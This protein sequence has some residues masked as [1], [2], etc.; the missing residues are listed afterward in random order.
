MYATH[1]NTYL[2]ASRELASITGLFHSTMTTVKRRAKKVAGS[3][4]DE[5]DIY[6]QGKAD[7][8]RPQLFP[9]GVLYG[10]P[11]IHAVHPLHREVADPDVGE[12]RLH[13][14]RNFAD[15]AFRD[16]E[17]FLEGSH[18]TGHEGLERNEAPEPTVKLPAP[19]VV[20]GQLCLD[21]RDELSKAVEAADEFECAAD[22]ARGRRGRGGGIGH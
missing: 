10:L 4:H 12:Q 1:T 2:K 21:A 14:G 19:S 17:H 7:R 20:V 16:A 15:V 3:L 6:P 18:L 9:E 22:V 5:P 13:A 8:E 11:A